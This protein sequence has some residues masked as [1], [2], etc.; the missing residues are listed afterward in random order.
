MNPLQ[1]AGLS[2]P[3]KNLYM[4]TK[5]KTPNTLLQSAACLILFIAFNACKGGGKEG[6]E[7]SDSTKAV[8][9]KPVPGTPIKY[10]SSKRYIFLTWDDA[11]QPPGTTN[12]KAAFQQ[13]GVKASFFIVGMHQFDQRRE[14]LVDSLRNGY[15]QF[16]IANHSYT[17][18]FRDHY[19]DFYTHPDSA[20][21]DFLKAQTELNYAVK[22]IRLPGNNSW[23]GKGELRG[24]K[25]TMAV[26][27][28]LDSLGFNV[29]GWDVEWRFV[30]KGGSI[31]I[32]SADE[33]VKEVNDKFD[34]AITNEPNAI[35]ILAHDRMFAKPQ[36]LDS[37][38]KFITTLKADKSNVFE[39]IDHYPLVQRK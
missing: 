27:K 30:N 33:M 3:G 6:K 38:N 36:Y 12:C 4:Y 17:H 35:V 20:V 9:A 15:P 25:S 11:P 1:K 19:K 24:P 21:Q 16:L 13:Q 23:V 2:L 34:N 14:V 7:G 5:S 32:Q 28:R 29:I 8:I 18:A 37:L 31:P 22:I 10:D 26:C 39:T